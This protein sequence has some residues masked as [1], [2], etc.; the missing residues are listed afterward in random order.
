MGTSNTTICV[1][2]RTSFLEKTQCSN[3][4]QKLVLKFG[5]PAERSKNTIEELGK[6]CTGV[7]CILVLCTEDAHQNIVLVVK[8]I[9]NYIYNPGEC[10]DNLEAAHAI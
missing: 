2:I 1:R 4:C 9:I 5:N 6:Y 10:L 8:K 3:L 7:M